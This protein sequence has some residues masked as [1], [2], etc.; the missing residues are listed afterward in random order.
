MRVLNLYAIR[1]IRDYA[2]VCQSQSV[3]SA[4]MHIK[5]GSPQPRGSTGPAGGQ[6]CNP[7][8]V[9]IV[10]TDT[11]NPRIR[12]ISLIGIKFP[13]RNKQWFGG[14]YATVADYSGISSSHYI[15]FGASVA[16]PQVRIISPYAI[17]GATDVLLRP[18][19][20]NWISNELTSCN[21]TRTCRLGFVGNG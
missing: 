3:F 7:I 11:G 9:I 20:K 12:M 21:E 16:C 4:N 6:E 17:G 2:T 19:L 15:G 13:V 18:P 14:N 10:P 5:R 1:L 8:I